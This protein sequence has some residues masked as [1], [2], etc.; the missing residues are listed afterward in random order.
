MSKSALLIVFILSFTQ[1]IAA[2]AIEWARPAPPSNPNQKGLL[3]FMFRKKKKPAVEQPA[4]S[5]GHGTSSSP[6]S[7]QR[8]PSA[9]VS[10]EAL[11]PRPSGG[12]NAQIAKN[13]NTHLGYALAAEFVCADNDPNFPFV[14]GVQKV[15]NDWLMR[16]DEDQG[17]MSGASASEVASGM[18]EALKVGWFGT[19]NQKAAISAVTDFVDSVSK[20]A[21]K[22]SS[23]IM[24][25]WQG[26]KAKLAIMQTLN[27]RKLQLRVRSRKCSDLSA[28]SRA[29]VAL[30]DFHIEPYRMGSNRELSASEHWGQM[31][32]YPPLGRGEQVTIPQTGVVLVWNDKIKRVMVVNPDGTRRV[33]RRWD[34]LSRRP[35]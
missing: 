24:T 18:K 19:A 4:V 17:S 34:F 35:R 27:S 1:P 15:I 13:T 9:S 6:D 28:E 25:Q 10:Q 7:D 31:Q 32:F 23:D 11:A 16:F 8:T 5:T 2:Q 22:D 3:D 33:A 30:K 29:S 14:D 12:L 20:N 26:V 21:Y